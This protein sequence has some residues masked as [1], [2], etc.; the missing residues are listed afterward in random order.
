M[1]SVR[2]RCTDANRDF[3]LEIDGQ[4]VERLSR[5]NLSVGSVWNPVL[6]LEQHPIGEL[7]ELDLEFD[8][9]V[10]Y[11]KTPSWVAIARKAASLL[12]LY[13]H[14]S[15]GDELLSALRAD[16]VEEGGVPTPWAGELTH[17][18]RPQ[19]PPEPD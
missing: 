19:S 7:E 14:Q 18:H 9:E 17:L 2:I 12:Q 13:G 1:K 15:L 8:A 16:T 11:E 6:T 10:R 5:F 3:S 4:K